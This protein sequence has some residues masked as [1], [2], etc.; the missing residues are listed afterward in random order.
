MRIYK[1]M[2]AEAREVL[3]LAS[4]VSGLS[5]LGVAVAVILVLILDGWSGSPVS[6]ALSLLQ[7]LHPTA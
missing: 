2:A 1:G 6:A 7:Y 4:I 5:V 3:W